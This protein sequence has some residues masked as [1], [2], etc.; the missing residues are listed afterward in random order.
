MAV[1]RH[2]PHSDAYLS[3][4]PSK[5]RRLNSDNRPRGDVRRL[6][7]Q[8][9]HEAM[10]Q[11][12]L[13]PVGGAAQVVEQVVASRTVQEVVEQMARENFQV[14]DGVTGKE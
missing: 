4:Q 5:R 3:G 8:S 1:P 6:I 7:E 2:Q 9:L 14:G 12:G 10:D 11:T 13:Q